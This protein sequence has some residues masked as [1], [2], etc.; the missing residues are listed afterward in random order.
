ML[1]HTITRSRPRQPAPAVLVLVA[2]LVAGL[3]LRAWVASRGWFYWDDLILLAQ[4]RE[5]G[6]GNCSCAPTTAT[7][8]LVP[9]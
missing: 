2:V 1:S 4:A 9:G 7:S 6:L 3:V 5:S 8:C